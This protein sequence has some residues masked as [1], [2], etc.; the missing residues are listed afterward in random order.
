ML[1]RHADFRHSV[2]VGKRAFG[3]LCADRLLRPPAEQPLLCTLVRGEVLAAD[4]NVVLYAPRSLDPGTSVVC[5]LGEGHLGR[6]ASGDIY[7]RIKV[8]D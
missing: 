4:D 8:V 7:A 2:E 5:H 1:D 3:R 6:G